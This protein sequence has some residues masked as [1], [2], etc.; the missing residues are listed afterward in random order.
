LNSG[1]LAQ[2]EG[3]LEMILRGAL[4]SFGLAFSSDERA[5]A[6]LAS[7]QVLNWWAS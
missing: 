3:N 1:K 6:E 4:E 5:A 2:S 7:R